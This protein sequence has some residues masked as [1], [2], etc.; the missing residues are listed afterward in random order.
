MAIR[1]TFALVISILLV[2]PVSSFADSI[3]QLV[4]FE[5]SLSDT[6]NIYALTFGLYPAPPS[7]TAG[8][9]TDGSDSTPSTSGPLGVWDQQ[10]AGMLGVPAPRPFLGGGGGTDYAFGGALT[11]DDPHCFFCNVIPDVG[12]QVH[13]YLGTHPGS[14]PSGT[15]YTFWAGANDILKGLSPQ[16]AVSNLSASINTLYSH[17]ARD[18]LWLNMPPLGETPHG[19]SSGNSAMLNLLSQD[20]NADWLAAIDSLDAQDPGIDI[21]G[22]N[23][24]GLFESIAADPSAYGFT[25]IDTAARGLNVNPNNYLF[26]DGLHPT[27]E[28][29]FW[30]ASLADSDLSDAPDAP[31]APTAVLIAIGLLAGAFAAGWRRHRFP[32]SAISPLG[33]RLKSLRG[34]TPSVPG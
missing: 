15:L 34:P 14:L 1:R 3:T 23:T 31:E 26:W 16:T 7:Y 24:Y 2:L 20:Y 29:H 10:L 8:Q 28:G 32:M 13:L 5:D 22:V 30:V 9:F 18:F 4:V 11:G 33:G 12:D 21:L 6:G 25:N 19:L 27:T 17:G